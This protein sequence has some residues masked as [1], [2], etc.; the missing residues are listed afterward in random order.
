MLVNY[1][2][3]EMPRHF[4]RCELC[5]N[6]TMTPGITFFRATDFMNKTVNLSSS[7]CDIYVCEIHF[8]TEDIQIRGSVKMLRAGALPTKEIDSLKSR[9]DVHKKDDTES[10]DIEA[11]HLDLVCFSLVSMFKYY[12]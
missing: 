1:L 10:F 12:S 5:P 8:N 11:V 2:I 9:I 7:E 4:R 6:T 3:S